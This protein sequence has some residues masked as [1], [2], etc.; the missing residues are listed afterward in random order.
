[1]KMLLVLLHACVRTAA[2]LQAFLERE[3]E[4]KLVAVQ[5][6]TLEGLPN[7]SLAVCA[8]PDLT[9]PSP[10]FDACALFEYMRHVCCKHA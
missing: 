7:P 2:E 4:F 1:M 6:W 9:S 8:F 3:H 10:C 5:T